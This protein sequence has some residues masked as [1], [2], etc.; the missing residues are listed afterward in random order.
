[1]PCQLVEIQVSG[2]PDQLADVW[3]V[4][5]TSVLQS[6]PCL[7]IHILG[8]QIP[9]ALARCLHKFLCDIVLLILSSI[10]LLG[11][12]TLYYLWLRS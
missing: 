7:L 5:P 4:D 6:L 1:M 9:K 10:P 3:M 12:D 11:G 8:L 2:S